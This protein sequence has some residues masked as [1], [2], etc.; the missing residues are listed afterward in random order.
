MLGPF[1]AVKFIKQFQTLRGVTTAV[2]GDPMLVRFVGQSSLNGIERADFVF[3]LV[4]PMDDV[5]Q[6]CTAQIENQKSRRA[7]VRPIWRV[8]R[9]N[10]RQ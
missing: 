5:G 4:I 9:Q 2:A 6:V 8:A 10:S 1:D 7:T 3:L